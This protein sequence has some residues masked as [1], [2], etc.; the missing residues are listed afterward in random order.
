MTARYFVN[1][2][3]QSVLV[4]F[5]VS[6]VVFLVV[7]LSGDPAALMLPAETSEAQLQAFRHALGFDRPLHEQFMLFLVRAVQGDFGESLRYH[8][9]ALSLVLERLPATAVLAVSA[10]ALAVVI[11]IPA[12]VI[13]AV[14]RNSIVDTFAVLLALLGQSMPIFWLGIVLILVFSV[15]LRLLPSTGGSGPEYLILP[16]VSLGMYSAGRITR[17]VRSGM[18]EVLGQDYVRTAQAK[19]LSHL[20]V[21]YG[22]ALRNALLPVATI[23]GLELG[24]ALG[25]AVITE[26]VFAWPGVGR[27]AVNAIFTRDYPVVQAAVF[28]VASLFVLVNLA[29]DLAYTFIDPR[30]QHD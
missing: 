6:L 3:A 13:S 8:Q 11:A 1:R 9:P 30:V 4:L 5:G 23:V 27:L 15:Q 17:L 21:V 28:M 10:L 18:L 16:A 25:G 14:K 29:V 24:S 12:G 2:L 22:H 19:G 26:T 7:H 20:G